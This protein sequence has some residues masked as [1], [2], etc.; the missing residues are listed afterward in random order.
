MALSKEDMELLA[1]VKEELG[2]TPSLSPDDMALLNEVR[3]ELT[4]EDSALLD[5]VRSALNP[6][7]VNT[8]VDPEIAATNAKLAQTKADVPSLDDL[9]ADVPKLSDIKKPKAEM[10]AA[11][12]NAFEHLAAGVELVNEGLTAGFSHE[13]E[14]AVSTAFLGAKAAL[15]GEVIDVGSTYN[16]ELN[17]LSGFLQEYK[18]AHPVLSAVAE[19]GATVPAV[20]LTGAATAVRGAVGAVAKASAA[21]QN[22]VRSG[23]T[24]GAVSGYGHS[25]GDAE[26]QIKDT[27]AGAALGGMTAG[28]VQSVG[29][30]A[31]TLY[32]T[33]GK[34]AAGRAVA[35]MEQGYFTYREQGLNQ[36][37]SYK[38]ALRDTGLDAGRL[39]EATSKAGRKVNLAREDAA[40][41]ETL[42]KPIP[43]LPPKRQQLLAEQA[44]KAV[45]VEKSLKS[46]GIKP[47]VTVDAPAGQVLLDT[48]KR[49]KKR[50]L[51]L[52]QSS[53]YKSQS[54]AQLFTDSVKHEASW[55]LRPFSSAVRKI[56]PGL[57]D[58]VITADF[59]AHATEMKYL[60]RASGVLQAASK[61]APKDRKA[62][63][64]LLLQGQWDQAKTIAA[65]YNG[66]KVKSIGDR[67]PTS[68]NL[69]HEIDSI[70]A[71]YDDIYNEK[72]AVGIDHPKI[73]NFWHRSVKDYNALNKALGNEDRNLFEVAL[74]KAKAD[75]GKDLTPEEEDAVLS[76]VLKGTSDVVRVTEKNKKRVF[77]HLKNEYLPMYHDAFDSLAVYITK[78]AKQI[79]RAR[80]FGGPKGTTGQAIVESP[81]D[82]FTRFIREALDN[83]EI[84]YKESKELI[85]AFQVRYG[86]G[87]QTMPEFFATLRNLGYMTRLANPGAALTNLMDLGWSGYMYG[88]GSTIKA[89]MSVA[90][91]KQLAR[92]EDVGL[93]I[94]AYEMT[95]PG[96]FTKALTAALK[97]S[98]FSKLDRFSKETLLNAQ[99][100]KMR[101]TVGTPEFVNRWEPV[102][103]ASRLA[104]LKK[105]LDANKLTYDGKLVLWHGLADVQ[106]ISASEMP[107][108]ALNNPKGRLFYAMKT[109]M[110]KQLDSVLRETVRQKDTKTAFK[111]TMALGLWL[112]MSGVSTQTLKSMIMGK[113]V[114]PDG[115]PDAVMENMLRVAGLS[116]FAVDQLHRT[117]DITGFVLDLMS[118]PLS[119][120]EHA[121]SD[122][123][124]N[125][126]EPG[127][128]LDTL[129]DLP[130]VG[131]LGYNW[132]GG[133]LEKT[134]SKKEKREK[135][136]MVPETVRELKAERRKER[137]KLRELYGR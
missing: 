42:T 17:R 47:G 80:A 133:G 30:A 122:V 100:D 109:Y 46:V 43:G 13:I 53:D 48:P 12:Y 112:T 73:D 64:N 89:A 93:K 56:S 59:D 14:A 90:R 130:V 3:T 77:K 65:K 9:K 131:A 2:S 84:T 11:G 5:E 91:G 15:S 58:R 66:V 67:K 96:R 51:S 114:N 28:L 120:L 41:R 111:N 82:P 123:K 10:K 25:E 38:R 87:E 86:P 126:Q 121:Y 70:K 129:Q 97:Y 45:E 61:L 132:F 1:S 108:G 40:L 72:Q 83:K 134:L 94:A 44:A 95:D 34:E 118:P 110:L 119:V 135:Q 18:E 63:S 55:F 127:S 54:R 21:P 71:L 102:L 136:E 78:S 36:A 128:S 4:P 101:K 117:G 98:L 29:A 113:E 8:P 60:T 68:I 115:V 24:Y 88:M 22:L 27:V 35:K 81:K 107:L 39:Q 99:W 92:L 76:R 23:T 79:A 104:R 31:R 33:V 105:D 49:T 124:K 6:E 69:A 20:A 116:T 57:A 19:A 37:E 7:P 50:T 137:A 32:D 74:S 26:Q 106:P 62:I 85:Q 103:G 75:K 52:G 125:V 16:A